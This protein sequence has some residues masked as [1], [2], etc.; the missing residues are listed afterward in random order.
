MGRQLAIS[1]ESFNGNAVRSI[2]KLTRALTP[3]G[4]RA[5]VKVALMRLQLTTLRTL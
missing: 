5:E 4:I 3:S 2:H 1:N